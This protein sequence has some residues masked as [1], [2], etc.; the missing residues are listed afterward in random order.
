MQKANFLPQ[1]V[2]EIL[3]SKIIMQS[4]W[5]AAFSI[6][7]QELELSQPCGVSFKTKNH[8]DGPFFF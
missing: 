2:F 7:T 5:L 3:K 4:D 8:I 6:T 1:I